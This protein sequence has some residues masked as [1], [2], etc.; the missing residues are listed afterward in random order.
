[1][2]KSKWIRESEDRWVRTFDDGWEVLVITCDLHDPNAKWGWVL[3]HHGVTQ[4]YAD[5]HTTSTG[6]KISVMGMIKADYEL[7]G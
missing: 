4:C 6:A 1:M 7:L 5:G 2:A 3:T